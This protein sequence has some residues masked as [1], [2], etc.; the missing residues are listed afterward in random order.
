MLS[1]VT[2]KDLTLAHVNL[3]IQEMAKAA[4]VSFIFFRRKKVG[5]G[6]LNKTY[7]RGNG[8]PMI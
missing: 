8:N 5:S 4:L 2:L 1:V 3:D 7:N 6:S